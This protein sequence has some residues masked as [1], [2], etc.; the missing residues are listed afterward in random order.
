MA[1][2]DVESVNI[3]P[4]LVAIET[5]DSGAHTFVCAEGLKLATQHQV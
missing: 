4:Y 2:I 3:V 1:W 5:L